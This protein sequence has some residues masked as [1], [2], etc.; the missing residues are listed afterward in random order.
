MARQTI[1]ELREENARLRND[2]DLVGRAVRM[3]ANRR[4]WCGDY[5]RVMN[6]INSKLLVPMPTSRYIHEVE[7]DIGVR[8]HWGGLPDGYQQQHM[9]DRHNVATAVQI[10]MRNH[11][12]LITEVRGAIGLPAVVWGDWT[13]QAIEMVEEP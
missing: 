5:E 2:L 4:G 6:K 8:M 3:E 7:Y 1:T 9:P 10:A 12:S 13:F 11:E